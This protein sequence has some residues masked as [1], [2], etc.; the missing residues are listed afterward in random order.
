MNVATADALGR[1]TARIVPDGA[2]QQTWSAGVLIGP[3][4]LASLGLNEE[5]T[6][7]LHN[8]LYNRGILRRSDVRYRRPE[9]HAALMAALRVDADRIVALYEE[10]S[11][12]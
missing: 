6:T 11:N 12:A 2:P 5:V 3:P 4:D 10:Q 7:R 9:I 8:E 1:Q